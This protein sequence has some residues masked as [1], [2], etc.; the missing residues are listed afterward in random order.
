MAAFRDL[1]D[2]EELC[3]TDKHFNNKLY[4][5]VCPVSFYLITYLPCRNSMLL[6]F[7]D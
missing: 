4:L 6:R 1:S 5:R 7:A 3:E 2:K